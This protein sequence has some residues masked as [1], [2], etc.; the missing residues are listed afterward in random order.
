MAFTYNTNLYSD[1]KIKPLSLFSASTT[2]MFQYS[3]SN[4]SLLENKNMSDSFS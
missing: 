2:D 3:I 1:K 4:D